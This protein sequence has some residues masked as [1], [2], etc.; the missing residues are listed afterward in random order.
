MP[1]AVGAVNIFPLIP[2]P[3]HTILVT[4]VPAGNVA[5]SVAVAPGQSVPIAPKTGDGALATVIIRVVVY[6]QPFIVA[7]KVTV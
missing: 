1:P 4:V 5:V 3:V 2:V 6:A 7:L